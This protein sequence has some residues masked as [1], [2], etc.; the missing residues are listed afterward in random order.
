M[1]YK[2]LTLLFDD[3]PSV[4]ATK[5]SMCNTTAAVRY[6]LLC[7]AGT[8]KEDEI[9]NSFL[10]LFLCLQYKEDLLGEVREIIMIE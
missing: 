4:C 9:S 10:R 1:D 2:I 5:M 3:K 6:V 7:S 8:Q